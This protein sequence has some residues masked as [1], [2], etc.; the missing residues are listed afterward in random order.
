M[1]GR[2]GE[3]TRERRRARVWAPW[4]P[5]AST[6]RPHPRTIEPTAYSDLPSS[7]GSPRFSV[8]GR[9]AER[10]SLSP[11]TWLGACA[12][13]GEAGRYAREVCGVSVR[14]LLSGFGV[15]GCLERGV[16]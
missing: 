11:A 13:G 16:G 2:G 3:G 15:R 5:N 14:M 10:R 4:V 1:G 9:G 6:H 7:F 8:P 12:F